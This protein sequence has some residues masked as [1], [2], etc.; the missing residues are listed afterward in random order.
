[1]FPLKAHSCHLAD[2]KPVVQMEKPSP[3]SHLRVGSQPEHPFL[4]SSLCPLHHFGDSGG[5]R[6]GHAWKYTNAGA[7]S[8]SPAWA[9]A[10][11]VVPGG[12]TLTLKA[13]RLNQGP[14]QLI[15]MDPFLFL[16]C[17]VESSDVNWKK[18]K[19]G[20]IKIICQSEIRDF[21]AMAFITDHVNSLIDQWFPGKKMFLNQV[22]AHVNISL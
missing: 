11:A 4:Q 21:S 15:I 12:C 18:K 13:R 3:G 9:P 8:D 16:G 19:S 6:Q 5:T 17:S 7:S 14:S 1:M 20:G 22:L 2:E 10:E